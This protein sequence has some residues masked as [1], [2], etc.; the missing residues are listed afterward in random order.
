MC[1]HCGCQ[2]LAA[3]ATLM[4][5]HELVVNLSG[6][7]RRALAAGDLELAAGRA[8]A[9]VTV[10]A[11]HT[12]VEE[13]ALFPAMAPEFT[14]HVTDLVDEH[15]AIEDVLDESTH[16]TPTDPT[17]PTRLERVLARLRE[18]IRKEEDGLFPAA[19]SSLTPDDWER[20]GAVR[21]F[22]GSAAEMSA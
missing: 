14:D 12:Q 1:E 3:I 6:E 22:V 9:I 5:E 19:L 17:W 8:R 4:R 21:R 10:L 2:D 13:Q 15:R 16:G 18:H 11:P 7:A 20:M